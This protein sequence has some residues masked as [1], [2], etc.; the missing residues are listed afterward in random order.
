MGLRKE[1]ADWR[2]A[3]VFDLMEQTN[4]EGP[5]RGFLY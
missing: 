4:R 2:S 5:D 3:L 1:F